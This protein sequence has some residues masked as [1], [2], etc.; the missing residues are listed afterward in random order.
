[1]DVRSEV[2]ELLQLTAEL[3]DVIR[4]CQ[5]FLKLTRIERSFVMSALYELVE[6]T[7]DEIPKS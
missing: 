4:N 3:S 7:N 5:R 2:Q 1:M 6:K